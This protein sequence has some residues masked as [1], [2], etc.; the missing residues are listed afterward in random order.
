MTSSNDDDDLLT[1]SAAA[2]LLG[3]SLSWLA[4]AR[5]RGDGPPFVKIGRSVRYPMPALR[6]FIR[7]RMRRS[8]VDPGGHNRG[9]RSAFKKLA[10]IV[11][12]VFDKKLWRRCPALQVLKQ[13]VE[14]QAGRSIT[15]RALR[16]VLQ[17]LFEETADTKFKE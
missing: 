11:I 7:T 15:D 13:E 14:R 6:E 2:K 9:R 1:P 3:V 4:K 10:P 5:M 12:D 8:T 16:S 17:R